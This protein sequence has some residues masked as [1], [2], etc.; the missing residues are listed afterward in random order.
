MMS[1]LYLTR[2]IGTEPHPI[3]IN[4]THVIAVHPA[5]T[6]DHYGKANWA[7]GAD[8]W[9]T[10]LDNSEGQSAWRVVEDYGTVTGAL[11]D[12]QRSATS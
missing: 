6:F 11:A 10:P 12:A 7:D 3:A 5:V 4:I 1:F 2:L 8:I 9:V